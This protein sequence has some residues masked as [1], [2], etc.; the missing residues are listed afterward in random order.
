MFDEQTIYSYYFVSFSK[1]IFVSSSVRGLIVD[2]KMER[3]S[4]NE[5][6]IF[7]VKQEKRDERR[8]IVVIGRKELFWGKE[9]RIEDN[10]ILFIF[11]VIFLIES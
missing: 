4:I 8:R 3:G 1:K 6:N 11:L 5:K 2:L 7:L 9:S 10:L